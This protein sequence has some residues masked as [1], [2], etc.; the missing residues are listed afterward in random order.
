MYPGEVTRVIARFD[1]PGRYVYHCHILSHEDH[2]MMRPY[3]VGPWDPVADNPF[4]CDHGHGKALPGAEVALGLKLSPNPFN[5]Q[6]KISF[7]LPATSHVHL[8]VYD[9]K[10]RLVNVL[11]E[12]D[13]AA[14]DYNVIW[15]GKDQSGAQVASGTYFARLETGHGT[16]I[17]KMVMLK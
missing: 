9:I 3:H 11:M 7:K 12:G 14:G 6:T 8:L 4:D 2:E 1:R 16:E 10:G 15:D 5:P 13:Q 17:Q